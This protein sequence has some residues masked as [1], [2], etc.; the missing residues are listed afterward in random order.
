MKTE[1]EMKAMLD[2]SIFEL[3]VTLVFY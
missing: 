3:T 1:E 2:K